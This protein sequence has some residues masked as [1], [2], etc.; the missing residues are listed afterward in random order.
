MSPPNTLL[1][2][3]QTHRREADGR[4]L[5]ARV[6]HRS[7]CIGAPNRQKPFCEQELHEKEEFADTAAIERPSADVFLDAHDKPP[8]QII[9]DLD[10]PTTR[11]RG[12]RKAGFL[13]GW[14]RLVPAR[15]SS[16]PRT[17][18]SV[19][20]PAKAKQTAHS[21]YALPPT[22]PDAARTGH[23]RGSPKATVR[24]VH[25]PGHQS[26]SLFNPDRAGTGE[27]CRLEFRVAVS[28]L[29]SAALKPVAGLNRSGKRFRRC[30]HA[31]QRH[32]R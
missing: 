12:I 1:T 14:L 17:V 6:S 20:P 19:R 15:A 11:C 25:R 28:D 3:H 9:L 10:A 4:S 32:K 31:V 24:A 29:M 18:R 23:V 8:A 5:P 27:K 2:P 26:R 16:P 21:Q 13:W 7:G 22:L 30:S